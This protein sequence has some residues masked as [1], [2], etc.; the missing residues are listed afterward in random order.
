M[1][2]RHLH[3]PDDGHRR[4]GET[5]APHPVDV[6]GGLARGREGASAGGST[7]VYVQYSVHGGVTRRVSYL[8][9]SFVGRYP[10]WEKD[11]RAGPLDCLS[12]ERSE[13][14]LEST[15]PKIQ[16]MTARQDGNRAAPAQP[17]NS[18]IA[19]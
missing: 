4:R 5:Q 12:V 9:N 3:W 2:V 19:C 6:S 15:A 16:L 10:R 8:S 1:G 14:Q 11:G 7:S 18:T 13:Q 17:C